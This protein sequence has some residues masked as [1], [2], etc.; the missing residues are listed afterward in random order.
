MHASGV[1][2]DYI[3]ILKEYIFM[4]FRIQRRAVE[5]LKHHHANFECSE[6]NKVGQRPSAFL[7]RFGSGCEDAALTKGHGLRNRMY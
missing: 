2:K 5:N 3:S 4:C 7:A 1:A 6:L